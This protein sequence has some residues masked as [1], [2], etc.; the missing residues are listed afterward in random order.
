MAELL[1]RGLTVV[2]L[3]RGND[4]T[5]ARQRLELALQPL[6]NGARLGR[7]RVIAGSLLE[8]NLG[9][10]DADDQD[11]LKRAELTVIHCAA[12]IRFNRSAASD[13]PFATNVG[14][15]QR[16]LDFCQ[17]QRTRAFHHV[18]TAYVGSRIGAARIPESPV[19][20]SA[21]GGNDYEKSKITAETMVLSQS[22][23]PVTIHRPSI[24]VGDSETFFTS[25]YHGFYAPLQIGA[26]F[27]NAFGFDDRAGDW[28]RQK[29]GLAPHDSKNLVPVDWVAAC[30]AHVACGQ[31]ANDGKPQ[32][33]HWTNPR[34]VPTLTMQEAIV[35]AIGERFANKPLKARGSQVPAAT[36]KEFSQQM[37][38]YQSYFNCDPSFDT[39][40]SQQLSGLLPC[41][42]LN[43]ALL[44]NMA[45]YAIDQGF[46]WPKPPLPEL[47]HQPV[48]AALRMT[49]RNDST[50]GES[51]IR[52]RLLGAGAVEPLDFK[53][54]QEKWFVEVLPK[55]T[56]ATTINCTGSL[57]TLAEHITGTVALESAVE[58]GYL[59]IAGYNLANSFTI[60]EHW[61][62]QIARQV[63]P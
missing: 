61:L 12:S 54:V 60:M 63:R 37:S 18:S 7:P 51:H 24:V 53:K 10:T 8:P 13:E 36:P 3:V 42:E 58:Q 27:A 29:I 35:T 50:P 32:I 38:V 34:P 46:G 4:L 28:F 52:L 62:S 23:F 39:S 17:S 5:A 45:R 56:K 9:I 48:V 47:P 40:L 15:C 21:L 25:T 16:L 55:E 31:V 1:K 49:P 44:T 43:L 33:F 30:I 2:A 59:S 22:R 6:E 57:T 14:G 11:F 41:P 19:V 26:Q 20:D